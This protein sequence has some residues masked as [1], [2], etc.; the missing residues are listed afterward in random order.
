MPAP[1]KESIS[2]YLQKKIMKIPDACCEADLFTG[3]AGPH[4]A[5]LV[6][7]VSLAVSCELALELAGEGLGALDLLHL[8]AAPAFLTLHLQAGGTVAPVTSLG[9]AGNNLVSVLF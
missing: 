8:G 2:I 6:T 9:A 7:G 5:F 4:A 3:R 1:L